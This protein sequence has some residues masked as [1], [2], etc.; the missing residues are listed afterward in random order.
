MNEG[1]GGN[2]RANRRGSISMMHVSKV[3]NSAMAAPKMATGLAK[4]GIGAGTG[5]A[6]A[7][8]GA[9]TGL[10]KAGIGAGTGLAR[11]GI[12]AGTGLAKAGIGGGTGLARAGLGVGMAGVGMMN[13]NRQHRK[14]K[15][16]GGKVGGRRL[17]RQNSRLAWSSRVTAPY[18][19]LDLIIECHEL[20]KKDSFT[21]ADAFAYIWEVP[22]G[23]NAGSKQVSKLPSRQEKEIGKT[24]VIR[25]N[26]NPRF[27]TTFRLDYK[28]HEH[29]TYVIRIYDE[30]LRYATDLKEH[31]FI[32][33]C[34]FTLGQLMGSTGCSIAKPLHCGKA[35][36]VLI[37]QEMIDTR[38]VLEFRFSGQ[39]LGAL[40]KKNSKVQVAKDVLEKM[41]KLNVAKSVLE[42]FD[43][44]FRLEKLNAEDQSW[45]IIWKS[46]V[47]KDTHNPTWNV[48]RLPLQLLC[49]DDPSSPLKITFWD[50][51]RFTADEL[52]GFVETSVGELVSKAKRGI[53]IMDVMVERKKLLRRGTKLKKAGILKVLKGSVVP[54]P[55]M[56]QYVAGDCEL[57]LMVAVDCTA[58]ANGDRE[59]EESLHFL[60]SSWLNDYQTA[61]YKI[62]AVFDAF[63]GNHRDYAL[64]GYGGT[65][66]G[67]DHP[68]FPMGERLRSADD[69]LKAYDRTLTPENPN[70]Q[71]GP[72]ANI[73][74]VIQAAI[75][76]AIQNSS[77]KQCY[78]TLVIL[79]AG[80]IDDI[81]ESI[82]A[83]CAAAED[84][85]LSIVLIGVGDDG[86][87][88]IHHLTGNEMGGLTHSNGVPISRDIVSFVSFND[89]Y[90]NATQTIS[91]GL[92]D[93]PEQ[94]V[95]HFTNAGILPNPTVAVPDYSHEHVV[96]SRKAANNKKKRWQRQ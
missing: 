15:N 27:T 3:L 17:K 64:W 6:K 25:E 88:V 76:R 10:A 67:V 19:K 79:T 38:E 54:I 24:E 95:Q 42:K 75:Y 56:L 33:G 96:K 74:N 14:H 80:Q 40:E 73:K 2:G 84:A 28:F 63:C 1:N 26:K 12:G 5:L 78:S 34:V 32:G 48:A 43:P 31:D 68:Y 37:G 55:S 4:A 61:I 90:G 60:D 69:L 82:D 53:P 66:K 45:T 21:N 18:T 51:N 85:P 35:F 36:V 65:I 92:K 41:E 8:I 39:G 49:Q 83:I 11:A 47:M 77:G 72:K 94:F 81:Q 52:V 16:K 23:F 30:D 86:F 59:D 89:C 50:W 22:P 9:G 13:F 93:I 29:Q 57:D 62:G 87:Q 7:G 71:L 70:L 91:E 58:G 46:E 20:P 44:Y